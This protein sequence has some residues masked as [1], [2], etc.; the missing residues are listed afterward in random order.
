MITRHKIH[1]AALISDDFREFG[2][3]PGWLTRSELLRAM[4]T[5]FCV[6]MFLLTFHLDQVLVMRWLDR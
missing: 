5:S 4:D 2:M 3:Q 6:D 1:V